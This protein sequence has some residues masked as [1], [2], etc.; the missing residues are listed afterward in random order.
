MMLCFCECISCYTYVLITSIL[1][2]LYHKK[3]IGEQDIQEVSMPGGIP[4]VYKVHMYSASLLL[5]MYVFY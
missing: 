4:F 1:I 3:D 5:S 2:M